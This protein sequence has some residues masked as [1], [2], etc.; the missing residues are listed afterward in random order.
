MLRLRRLRTIPSFKGGGW[1]RDKGP[2]AQIEPLYNTV[3]EGQ[4]SRG[5][6]RRKKWQRHV[7]DIPGPEWSRGESVRVD[8][9]S[10]TEFRGNLLQRNRRPALQQ[11][12]PIPRMRIRPLMQVNRF[13]HQCL[14]QGRHVMIQIC[15]RKTDNIAW[16][17]VRISI[18][19]RR[20]HYYNVGTIE[21]RNIVYYLE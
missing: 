17:C 21:Q 12:S 1:F 6:L 3:R 20:M 11:T 5:R 2:I 8:A 14:S 9:A 18:I 4:L 19:C 13:V 10:L 16:S 7:K 15:G